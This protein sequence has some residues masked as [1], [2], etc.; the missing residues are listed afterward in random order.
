[1]GILNIQSMEVFQIPG[2]TYNVVDHIDDTKPTEETDEGYTQWKEIDTLVLQ[3][4]YATVSDEVLGRILDIKTTARAAWLRIQKIYHINKG[5][6]VAALEGEFYNLT[7]NTCSSMDDYCQR[8]SDLIEQLGDIDNPLSESRLILQLFRGLPAEFDT[9]ASFINQISDISWDTTRNMIQLEQQRVATRKTRLNQFLSPLKT[10]VLMLH[11]TTLVLINNPIITILYEDGVA[12]FVVE[13]A[14]AEVVV[15]ATRSNSGML[16]INNGNHIS[17]DNNHGHHLLHPTRLNPLIQPHIT[18][19][20]T[21]L[22]REIP[23]DPPH[24]P[25]LLTG[26]LL[27]LKL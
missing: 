9:V 7:L 10:I 8:H 5:S 19:P 24:Q 3:W 18:T 2:V 25:N 16:L 1:M 17:G 11:H 4:I 21:R 6:R 14:P 15:A 23:N 22:N 20:F 27:L 12:V 13:A 26:L